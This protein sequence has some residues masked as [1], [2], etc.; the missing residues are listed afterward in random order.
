MAYD[1]N[2]AN[3]V[4]AVQDY[5]QR[6]ET[7]FVK[8]IP[9]FINLAEKQIA[10]DFK[11]LWNLAV[12]QG[13]LNPGRLYFDKPARWRKTVSISVGGKVLPE[14]SFEYLRAVN[15][16]LSSGLPQFWADYDY[17]NYAISP[18]ADIAYLV[19]IIYYEQVLPLS[20][21]VSDNLITRE[22]P[23]LLLYATLMSTLR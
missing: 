23:Q 16:D 5:S 15:T 7:V 4:Q 20:E 19:E 11:A 17:N 12:A 13:T 8:N 22:A 21:F 2:Y 3:L 10:S 9:L 6:Y 1:L 18:L 14:R